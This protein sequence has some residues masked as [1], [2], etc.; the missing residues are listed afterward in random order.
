M[1]VSSS[2]GWSLDNKCF[3]SDARPRERRSVH[4]HEDP[5]VR[6]GDAQFASMSFRVAGLPIESVSLS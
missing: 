2:R 5:T 4:G 3:C 1:I 6:D